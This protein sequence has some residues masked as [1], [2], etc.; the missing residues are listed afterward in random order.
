[1]ATKEPLTINAGAELR[2]LDPDAYEALPADVRKL[3]EDATWKIEVH[4]GQR[5]PGTSDIEVRIAVRP[6]AAARKLE[7]RTAEGRTD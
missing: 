2:R 5:R 1:M 4:Q 7:R 6:N 3:A